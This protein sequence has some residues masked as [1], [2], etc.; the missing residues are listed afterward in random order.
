MSSN[1]LG[2]IIMRKWQRLAAKEERKRSKG[3]FVVYAKGGKRYVVP[4]KYLDHPIFQVLLDMAEEEFGTRSHGPLR[5]PCEEEL[6][7]HLVSLLKTDTAVDM[8]KA[9]VSFTSI[10]GASFSSLFPL[11]HCRNHSYNIAL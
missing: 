8:E 1:R 4:L 9:L 2:E 3:H 5:V 7:E 10:R 6:M 11:C